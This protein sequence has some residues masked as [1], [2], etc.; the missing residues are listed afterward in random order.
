MTLTPEQIE[1]SELRALEM[2]VYDD[3]EPDHLF[4]RR[5]NAN[6][7]LVDKTIGVLR[8]DLDAAASAGKRRHH[9]TRTGA[10]ARLAADDIRFFLV[11]L[12]GV[13]AFA[14]ASFAASFAG[15][16]AMAPNTGLP[17]YL[18]WLVPLFID[19]P[20]IVLSLATL[21]FRARGQ[22]VWHT[23]AVVILLTAL[24]SAINVAHVYGSAGIQ[25]GAVG[26]ALGAVVMGG[27]PWLV[28]V[29]FEELGRLGI[30]PP[31]KKRPAPAARPTTR[32]KAS[33]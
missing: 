28:L 24:S 5:T 11:I 23:W 15:Q 22:R 27:A 13:V 7:E 9:R 4:Q 14:L 19:L 32:K 20:I 6:F 29:S 31:E 18:W 26:V 1:S 30:K 10:P 17:E 3:L 33:K 25:N 8:H 2:P 12:G 16:Y 21:I